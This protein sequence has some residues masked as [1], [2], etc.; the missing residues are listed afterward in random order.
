MEGLIDTV[1]HLFRKSQDTDF[2]VRFGG[3]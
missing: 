2:G 3:C 1:K